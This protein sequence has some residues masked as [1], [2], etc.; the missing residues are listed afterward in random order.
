MIFAKHEFPR[1][2]HHALAFY[3][4][5]LTCLQHFARCWNNV[6]RTGKNTLQPSPSV[7]RSTYDLNRIG[8]RLYLAEL[9]PVSIRMLFRTDDFSNHKGGKCRTG[10]CHLFYF[11]A[12]GGEC[13]GNGF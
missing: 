8:P 2:T 9:K 13:I 5:D 4:A 12:N 10:V 6:T 11:E 1:R 3:T 7:S